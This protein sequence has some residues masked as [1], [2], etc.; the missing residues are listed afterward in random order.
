M[1]RCQIWP[2][3]WMA[4]QPVSP[5]FINYFPRS[6]A[7]NTKQGKKLKLNCS[8]TRICDG[9]CPQRATW[10]RCL[11][12]RNFETFEINGWRYLRILSREWW[13]DVNVVVCQ[14]CVAMPTSF[15]NKTPD[16]NQSAL[17]YLSGKKIYQLTEFI[18]RKTL[19][20]RIANVGGTGWTK[21][22][23]TWSNQKVGTF[24]SQFNPTI[25]SIALHFIPLSEL[26]CNYSMP[27]FGDSGRWSKLNQTCSVV[28]F[29]RS[30]IFYSSTFYFGMMFAKISGWMHSLNMLGFSC[31]LQW[32]SK[33]LLRTWD[34]ILSSWRF[35]AQHG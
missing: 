22:M 13:A 4:N 6:V 10:T 20:C 16:V 7:I 17:W 2:A 28:N 9:L 3:G 35:K 18:Y 1:S 34:E 8:F 23:T 19:P 31:F 25:R 33:P 24:Q 32:R 29:S 12:V 26:I 15:Y 5:G 11:S 21:C 30:K 14:S 27:S